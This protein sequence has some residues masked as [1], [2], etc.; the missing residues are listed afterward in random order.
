MIGHQHV[1]CV[2]FE[3]LQSRYADARP[4]DR[5]QDAC[6]QARDSMLGAAPFV[7]CGSQ[8][9]RQSQ[10]QRRHDNQ[11]VDEQIGA[12]TATEHLGAFGPVC[13]GCRARYVLDVHG[14]PLVK[15]GQGCLDLVE[16]RAVAQVEQAIDLALLPSHAPGQVGLTSLPRA[17]LARGMPRRRLMYSDSIVTIASTAYSIASRSEKPQVIAS[18]MSGKVTVMPSLAR[19]NFAG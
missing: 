8:H 15:S 3:L 11:G 12:Q 9:R 13:L 14:E 2:L 19:S 16:A 17:L 6:P 1:S 5:E 10:H 4:A 18:G 7:E